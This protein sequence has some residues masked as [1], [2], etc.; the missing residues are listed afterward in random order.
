MHEQIMSS[1][2]QM[3][4]EGA[5]MDESAVQWSG[6]DDDD[7]SDDNDSDEDG[8]PPLEPVHDD[9]NDDVKSM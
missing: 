7:T 9:T 8:A 5:Q 4:K 2:Q 3:V 1:L 6:D